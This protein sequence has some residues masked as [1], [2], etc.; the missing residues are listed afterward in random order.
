LAAKVAVRRVSSQAAAILKP[1]QL[2]VGVQ[3]GIEAAAHAARCFVSNSLSGDRALLKLDLIN[4][5][6]SIGLHRDVIL[7][8]VKHNFPSL[9]LLKFINVCYGDSSK[10]C[11]QNEVI[12]AEEGAHVEIKMRVRL[13]G[14]LISVCVR[15]REVRSPQ[16]I[17]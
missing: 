16:V 15:L 14:D 8:A 13:L 3:L 17:S 5:F 1:N 9:G 6:N 4:A 2:G 11:L 12:L 10:L 7:L